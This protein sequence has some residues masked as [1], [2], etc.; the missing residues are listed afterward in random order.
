ML[1]KRDTRM[2]TLTMKLYKGYN[3]ISENKLLTNKK[4]IIEF[5]ELLFLYKIMGINISIKNLLK[6]DKNINLLNLF[7]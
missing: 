6:L 5:N 2:F 1:K 4:I 7:I 3:S